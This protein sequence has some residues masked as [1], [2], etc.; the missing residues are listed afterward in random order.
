MDGNFTIY[1]IA[2][3]CGVTLG[4]PAVLFYLLHWCLKIIESCEEELLQDDT[5]PPAQESDSTQK[6]QLQHTEDHPDC[7]ECGDH[8]LFIPPD[9]DLSCP[10]AYYTIL[11]PQTDDNTVDILIF[12]DDQPPSY[13]E[14]FKS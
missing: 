11:P 10:T 2:I 1:Y 9:M 4:I 7:G 14:L 8:V 13:R 6:C 12:G 5:S 3:V